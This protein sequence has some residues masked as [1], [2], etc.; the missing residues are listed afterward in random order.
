VDEDEDSEQFLIERRG[1]SNS[2]MHGAW[3]WDG[4]SME[5]VGTSILRCFGFWHI[6]I[7]FWVACFGAAGH[8]LMKYPF[9]R[10]SSVYSF[11]CDS[12]HGPAVSFWR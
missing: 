5:H 7:A 6:E 3:V 1:F 11:V 2:A 10:M 4:W 8:D 12:Y 9:F